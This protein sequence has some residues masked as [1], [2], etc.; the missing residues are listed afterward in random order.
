MPHFS[1]SLPSLDAADLGF[2]SRVCDHHRYFRLLASVLSG[3]VVT[4]S[5]SQ[6]SHW[7]QQLKPS[8]LGGELS[9][10]NPSTLTAWGAVSF[11]VGAS[12]LPLPCLT[13]RGK[14][15]RSSFPVMD[16]GICFPSAGSR[17]LSNLR[18][19]LLSTCCTKWQRRQR[20]TS[21]KARGAQSDA[22]PTP[23]PRSL[24]R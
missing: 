19:G 20:R 11:P 24:V 14:V 16:T 7:E 5:R 13:L 1:A 6:R 23:S 12:R 9:F 21:C 2:S 18:Y 15:N 22:P 8:Y 3:K 10:P 17:A 4:S